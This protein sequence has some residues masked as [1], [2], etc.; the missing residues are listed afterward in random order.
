[1]G[2]CN[3]EDGSIQAFQIY[4]EDGVEKMVA[5]VTLRTVLFILNCANGSEL[6]FSGAGF[7]NSGI[8][9]DGSVQGVEPAFGSDGKVN[10]FV[11]HGIAEFL[12][13]TDG[14]GSCF[15]DGCKELGSKSLIR[16]VSIDL[17]K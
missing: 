6:G 7:G 9:K 3:I 15:G 16:S 1:M 12:H 5:S 13:Q 17:Y 2:S 11:T 10:G 4:E 14:G 8:G